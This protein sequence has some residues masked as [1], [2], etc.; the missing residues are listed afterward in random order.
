MSP[1]K[2]Y[3]DELAELDRRM[4]KMGAMARESISLAVKSFEELDLEAVERVREIDEKTLEVFVKTEKKIIR[5]I[6]LHAPVA[7]DLRYV[8]TS[9][10][11]TTDFDRIVR[12][13]KDICEITERASAQ[14]LSHFKVLVS[15][16]RLAEMA[17]SMVDL[18]VESFLEGN[19]EKT[20][21]VFKL[22]DMVDSLYDEIFREVLTY[23]IESPTNMTMGM[24]YQF[25]ARYLERIAD[26]AC[27]I[28]ERT[29]YM[30]TGSRV[31]M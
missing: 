7:S 23:M 8:T 19:L 29:V 30:K 5:I 21:Q 24:N 14:G 25:V 17:V 6:A 9:L 10:K 26:H 27:N 2:A 12:Y 18:S 22:E 13:A 16:P 4:A 11:I 1:R 15:I 3:Q 20:E 28:A 31:Q